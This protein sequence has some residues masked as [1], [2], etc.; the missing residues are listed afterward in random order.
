[1][2]M[3]TK[4][5][6]LYFCDPEGFSNISP[7]GHSSIVPNSAWIQVRNNN[8]TQT[9]ATIQHIPPQPQMDSRSEITS[10]HNKQRKPY[11]MTDFYSQKPTTHNNDIQIST[12]TNKP[13]GP[14]NTTSVKKLLNTTAYNK[15]TTTK[16]WLGIVDNEQR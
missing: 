4:P 8:R 11:L 5:I 15:T 7:L 9:P 13:R 1:M 12:A 10:K 14:Q 6:S 2:I 3:S 16:R